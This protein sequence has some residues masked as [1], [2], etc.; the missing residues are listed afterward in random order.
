M[1][2][3]REQQKFG[4]RV[5]EWANAAGVSRSLVYELIQERRIASTKLGAA[6]IITTHPATFL[7][8]LGEAA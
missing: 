2:T 3:Q 4:W 6:R 7:A 8:S 5:P 1:D